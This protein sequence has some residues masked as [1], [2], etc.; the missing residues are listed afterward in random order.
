ML[1]YD[2]SR[3]THIALVWIVLG[4]ATVALSAELLPEVE[5]KIIVIPALIVAISL[6]I[7]EL[8]LSHGK[9]ESSD[10]PQR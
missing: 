8:M 5:S 2:I 9:I 7:Y 10:F 6:T 1:L 3:K 4:L